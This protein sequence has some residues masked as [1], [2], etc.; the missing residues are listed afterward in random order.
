MIDTQRPG[1][2]IGKD[3][4]GPG[5]HD[6]SSHLADRMRIV[7][8]AGRAGIARPAVGLGGS[9]GGEMGSQEGMQAAGRVVG[10]RRA[11][12]PLEWV[13]IR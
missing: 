7:V 12:I 3:A 4:V 13:A 1:F 9:T 11:E 5:E 6:M 10:Q 2:E 8:D